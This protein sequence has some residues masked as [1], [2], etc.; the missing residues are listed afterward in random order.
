MSE[1]RVALNKFV[2]FTY[3]ITDE[4]GNMIEQVNVPVGYAYGGAQQMFDKV[5][6]AI[7][8]MQAG[9]TVTVVLAPGEAYG[10]HDPEL[11]FTDDIDN[12]PPQ[13]R[14]VGAQIDFQNDGGEV[15]TF[16]VTAI[17]DDKL[18]VDGNHPMAGKKVKFHLTVLSVRDATMEE[19]N[20]K[21]S[22]P[23]Q[24]LH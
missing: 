16:V 11:T 2:E 12:V 1:Q 7:E 3:Q 17:D 9:E 8:G 21:V 19:I 14:H 5:E 23:G 4:D 15:K 6:Q 10:D 20:G 22:Q 13:F 24:Q 18:T